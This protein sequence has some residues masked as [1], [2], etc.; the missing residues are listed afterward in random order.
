GHACGSLDRRTHSIYGSCSTTSGFVRS[1]RRGH[2]DGVSR[3]LR[4]QRRRDQS[5]VAADEIF[6]RPPRGNRGGLFAFVAH[7]KS[8]EA[9]IPTRRLESFFI[10]MLPRLISR[11]VVCR[12][13][14]RRAENWSML[15][16]WCGY[17]P[18]GSTCGA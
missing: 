13:M 3:G 2:L 10:W 6:L 9:G 5:L 7:L 16:I 1:V 12:L 8:S 18:F 14:P 4:Q 15:S 17:I 11:R